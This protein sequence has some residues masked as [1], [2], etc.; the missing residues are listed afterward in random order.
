MGA[1]PIAAFIAWVQHRTSHCG[2]S[3]GCC[4]RRGM[5]E[6]DVVLEGVKKQVRRRKIRPQCKN[7]TIIM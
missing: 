3:M 2:A 5:G 6:E 1:A 4:D 7:F